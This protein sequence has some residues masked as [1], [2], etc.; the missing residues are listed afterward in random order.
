[1]KKEDILPSSTVIWAKN[2]YNNIKDVPERT[3]NS[4][5]NTIYGS[6]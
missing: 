2:E 5:I 4:P 3:V 1:M 6:G